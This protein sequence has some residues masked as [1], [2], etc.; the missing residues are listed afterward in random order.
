MASSKTVLHQAHELGQSIWY[1][2][3]RRGLLR[4]GGLAALVA[5]G[6]RGLTSNPTIFEKAIVASGDYEEDLR[7]LVAEGR[8][9]ADIYEALALED[10]RGACDL[11]TGVYEE[12][13]RRGR[14]RLAGGAARVRRLHRARR[15]RKASP[16]QARRLARTS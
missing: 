4:N 7:R 12:S 10:I 15:W 14:P 8:S 16:R 11:L 5:K 6:V 9:T 13:G 1:D 3:M 2:N